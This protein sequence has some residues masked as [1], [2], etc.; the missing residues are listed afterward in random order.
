MRIIDYQWTETRIAMEMKFYA[1]LCLYYFPFLV[2][3]T[4]DGA[5]PTLEGI[6]MSVS[7]VTNL[8]FF[9]IECVQMRQFGVVE[10][11]K[12]GFWNFVSFTQFLGFLSLFIIRFSEGFEP[13]QGVT[14]LNLRVYLSTCGFMQILFFIRI[15]ED[16]G[17]LV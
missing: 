16:Y 12:E 8:F 4:L 2:V 14:V 11:F 5:H 3:M 15:Y 6:I 7:F 17:F 1:F 10:Y 13:V 9:F